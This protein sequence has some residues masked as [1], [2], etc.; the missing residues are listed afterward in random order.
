VI[1]KKDRA[2]GF[3]Q[4][5]PILL[6]IVDFLGKIYYNDCRKNGKLLAADG[7]HDGRNGSCAE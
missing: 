3:G 4:R 2:G 1:T 5:R 7:F 6:Y